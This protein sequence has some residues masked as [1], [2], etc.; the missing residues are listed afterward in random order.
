MT[1]SSWISG[2]NE[3]KTDGKGTVVGDPEY[4]QT[5]ARSDVC[6]KMLDES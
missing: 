4:K 3:T 6:G 1:E 2:R 5:L